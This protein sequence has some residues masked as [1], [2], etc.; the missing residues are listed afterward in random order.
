MDLATLVGL[1][2]AF[3]LVLYG[4][5][6]GGSLLIFWNAPSLLI[7]VGG[8]VGATLINY[9]LKDVLGV[10]KVVKNVFFH[11]L[12]SPGELIKMLADMA[13]KAR[14]GGILSLEQS[15]K[16]VNDEYF[17]KG[18][19]LVVDGIE[20]SSVRGVLEK[21]IEYASD[22]HQK[23]AEVFTTLG[24]FAPALGMIGTLIGLVQ[25]LQ[26]LEDPSQIGP[27]M[28]VALITT[29]YGALLAN[30]L[31]LPI[32]GKLK[33]RS[34]EEMLVKELVLEGIVSIASGENPRI[35][36]QKLQAFLAPRLRE[37]S[38]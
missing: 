1:F 24:T 11:K 4:I 25:M 20:I 13:G 6:S 32:A 8:T 22:R 9:P 12:Q 34:K 37:Y 21:E 2:S 10:V 14:K 19:Q 30:L 38:Q 17:S 27:A 7:V 15:V 3:F 26:N 35:M 33:T 23:G 28:A 16:E 31:F 36:E 5:L 29:F 18:L